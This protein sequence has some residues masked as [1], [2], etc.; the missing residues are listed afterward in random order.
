MTQMPPKLPTENT[1]DPVTALENDQLNQAAMVDPFVDQPDWQPLDDQPAILPQL[2][3]VPAQPRPR[4]NNRWWRS[5]SVRTKA[6]ALAIVIGTAPMLVISGIVYSV[7]SRAVARETESFER[8]RVAE[9]QDKVNQFMRDRFSDIRV[10]ADF[11]LFTNPQLRTTAT[12]AQRTAL[13]NRLLDHHRIYDTIAVANL[14]GDVIAQTSEEPIGNVLNRSYIQAAIQAEGA[15]LSQPQGSSAAG[16]LSIYSASVLKDSVSGEPVGYIFARMPIKVLEEL[17]QSYEGE[18]TQYYMIDGDGRVFIAPA[19]LDISA[20]VSL[21]TIFPSL[22]ERVSNQISTLRFRNERTDSQQLLAYAPSVQ[23]PGLPD[24]RW[25]TIIALDTTVASPQRDLLLT[26]VLGTGVTALVMS[27]IAA[28]V[29]NRA[30]RPIR[31][32]ATAVKKI[33]QGELDTRLLVAGED[34]FGILSANINTMA[35]QLQTSLAAQAFEAAQERVLTVAKGSGVQQRED[36]QST[37]DQT[38]EGARTLLNLDRVVVYQFETNS[39]AGFS[40]GLGGGVIAESVENSWVSALE[41][42]IS[43]SCIPNKLREAYRQGRVVAVR[44]VT[45]A[46]F[47]PDHVSLLERLQVKA[48]MVLPILGGGQLF[49]LLVA[50]ACAAPRKWQE[51]EIN[52]LKRLGEELGLTFYRVE[53]LERTSNLAKEQQSL[54]EALQRRALELLQEVEPISRGD[55]TTRAKVTVDEI[56]TIADSYNATVDN[57]R[58]IILQV[59]S[60]A[61][62][63]VSTT[64]INETS[65]QTLSVE[66]LRQAEEIAAA[67]ELVREMAN[68]VQT[69]AV[70]AEQ[71]E[72]AVQLAAQTVKEGDKVMNRTVEGIQAVRTTVADTARKIKHLGE[73]SQKIS[74]VVELISAFAAQTN[75]LALNA[76]IEASRAGEEGRGF[77]VVANE[78]RALARQSAGATEEIRGLVASIQAETNEVAA[79]ME[80]G[81]E[82]V[83]MGTKLVDETRQSLNKITAVST[84]ISEL[85]EAIAQSTVEQSQASE[86]VTHTMK[87]VAEIANKTSAEVSQV[88]SSFEQLRKVA[89]SLQKNIESFKVK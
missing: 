51:T 65:V 30:T 3:Q 49:G 45:K 37:L 6:T 9:L 22:D 33:G 84:Q 72:Q 11:D 48:S 86:T 62:Q 73:S 61:S 88:S 58:Q 57:L 68:T 59:Q 63:V 18:N 4:S 78:V 40:P 42:P 39:E 67:L 44:D 83:V 43:D 38:V 50:H 75:M 53:L 87:G 46:G 2:E 17:V 55:L 13:L 36:L 28:D 29:A 26:L 24:L 71:A 60:A 56:G 80:A 27:A 64:S 8:T 34:E 20:P 5:I 25:Q 47:H 12:N 14:D 85:V 54:K 66:A 74:K 81:I 77:A 1:S 70:N 23:M 7:A 89:Q 31:S 82:Q 15:V 69:I 32:A 79:A 10:M 52:L 76:S 41:Y 16:T 19:S 35:T 21:E